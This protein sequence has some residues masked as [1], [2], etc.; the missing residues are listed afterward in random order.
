MTF[1]FGSIYFHQ[2]RTKF[3]FNQFAYANMPDVTTS[4]GKPLDFVVFLK[5]YHT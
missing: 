1:V 2:T 5:N 3:V 4:Y